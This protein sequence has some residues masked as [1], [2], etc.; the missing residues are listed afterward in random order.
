MARRTAHQVGPHVGTATRKPSQ[1]ASSQAVAAISVVILQSALAF[2]GMQLAPRFPVPMA[3][4]HCRL[5]LRGRPQCARVAGAAIIRRRAVPL[6][7][8]ANEKDAKHA[9]FAEVSAFSSTPSFTSGVAAACATVPCRIPDELQVDQNQGTSVAA[10]VPSLE[11]SAFVQDQGTS[12][13]APVPTFFRDETVSVPV[14]EPRQRLAM[15]VCIALSLVWAATLSLSPPLQIW[16]QGSSSSISGFLTVVIMNMMNMF[17]S[18][19]GVAALLEHL[20]GGGIAA[21]W[22]GIAALLENLHAAVEPALAAA[23]SKFLVSA[24]RVIW[25]AMLAAV[26]ISGASALGI[27]V[28]A[29]L[30]GMTAAA[31]NV[32]LLACRKRYRFLRKAGNRRRCAMRALR[33]NTLRE[34]VFARNG[35]LHG[36][37]EATTVNVVGLF[38]MYSAF[39]LIRHLAFLRG[40]W[41][42]ALGGALAGVAYA[43]TIDLTKTAVLSPGGS[44]RTHPLRALRGGLWGA[45]GRAW[46]WVRS[47]WRGDVPIMRRKAR[48]W[49]KTGASTA[50]AL[51]IKRAVL[52]AVARK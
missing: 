7:V 6:L 38:V 21:L 43:A 24:T 16:E 42:T 39:S 28:S 11:A 17:S 51:A 34:G 8:L 35:V 19:E 12:L 32:P 29:T 14:P 13:A 50:L 25:I 15:F 26:G 22:V 23:F 20:H 33:K 40:A 48:G 37:S 46:R 9:G 31:V 10:P 44:F 3:A 2:S 5:G 27:V 41:G 18:G 45:P 1:P 52:K 4:Q 36:F 49:A 47:G 30:T